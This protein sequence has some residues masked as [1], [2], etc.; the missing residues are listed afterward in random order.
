M[1]ERAERTRYIRKCADDVERDKAQLA[2]S[3]AKLYAGMIEAW[4]SEPR[5]D[6]GELV[7]ASG[8]AKQQ[9]HRIVRR[10]PD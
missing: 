3:R 6:L 8:M 4:T 9:I 5:L 10:P 2:A 7:V 1:T